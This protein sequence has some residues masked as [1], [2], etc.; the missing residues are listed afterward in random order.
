MMA[1]AMM[2]VATMRISCFSMQV[3]DGSLIQYYGERG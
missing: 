2:A 3:P 1:K